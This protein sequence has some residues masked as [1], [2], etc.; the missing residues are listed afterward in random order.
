MRLFTDTHCN[1]SRRERTRSKGGY[2]FC[3]KK[4]AKSGRTKSEVE[5]K[6]VRAYMIQYNKKRKHEEREM[7]NHTERE[8]AAGQAGKEAD[9]IAV[10]RKGR[11][12]ER[13][14]NRDRKKRSR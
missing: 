3:R 9:G 6:R 10:K 5:K 11:E 13:D 14:E 1:K 7:A 8:V 2:T 12:E 4:S